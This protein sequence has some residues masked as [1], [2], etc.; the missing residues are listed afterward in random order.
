MGIVPLFNTWHYS[1]NIEV[2]YDTMLYDGIRVCAEKPINKWSP[3]PVFE[4]TSEGDGDRL[5]WFLHLT[6]FEEFLRRRSANSGNPKKHFPTLETYEKI[7][8]KVGGFLSIDSYDKKSFIEDYN[9]LRRKEHMDG[10][11]LIKVFWDTNEKFPIEWLKVA[12]LITDKVVAIYLIADDDKSFSDLNS[13]SI[14]D[15]NGY[16]MYGLVKIIEHLCNKHYYSF[17]CGISGDY[18]GYKRKIFLDRVNLKNVR[19]D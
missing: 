16:C 14:L 8:E 6:T 10:R 12:R 1:Y 11:E 13:A 2:F 7:M 18:G 15:K 5:F 3:L 17:D 4:K 9:L 19:I